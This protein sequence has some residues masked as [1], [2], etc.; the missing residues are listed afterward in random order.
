MRYK[1]LGFVF[2]GGLTREGEV[3]SRILEDLG[4]DV[5]SLMCKSG[6]VPK[7]DLI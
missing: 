6:G 7:E 2:C 3:V 4:F 5:V 1:K